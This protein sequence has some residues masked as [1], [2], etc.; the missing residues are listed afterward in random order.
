MSPFTAWCE[1]LDV[2]TLTVPYPTVGAMRA[3]L[4][5][6]VIPVRSEADI[7]SARQQGRK[8]ASELGF[9]T[10]EQALIATAIS[11]LARNMIQYARGGEVVM[12]QTQ[13]GITRGLTVVARDK[14]PGIADLLWA[15]GDGHSSSGGL[16]LG[17]PGSKRLMD[18]FAIESNVGQGTVVTV[19]KWKR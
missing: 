19:T 5:E 1:G 14:G 13:E 15:M 17:L 6:I 10:S 7:V 11:E 4:Q 18:D 9:S 16:G 2:L 3:L 8:L 12:G